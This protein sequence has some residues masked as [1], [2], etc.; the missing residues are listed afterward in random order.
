MLEAVEDGLYLL[1]VLEVPTVPKVMRRMLL[2][3]LEA[4]EGGLCLPEVL[5]KLEVPE[6]VE[7]VELSEVIR[8]A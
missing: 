8:R 3:M 6:M 5:E 2:R 1:E 7:V 4:V